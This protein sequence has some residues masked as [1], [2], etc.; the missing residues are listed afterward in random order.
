M[1][2]PPTMASR[3]REYL[4]HSK[5]KTDRVFT[6]LDVLAGLRV[7]PT[8]VSRCKQAVQRMALL[9]EIAVVGY[10]PR[11]KGG[12][13]P[14]RYRFVAIAAKKEREQPPELYSGALAMQNITA[15]WWNHA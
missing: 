12:T 4:A 5:F 2:K 3:V 10:A 9:G 13:A 1:T 7:E 6:I 15:S 8:Q 11:L 14:K